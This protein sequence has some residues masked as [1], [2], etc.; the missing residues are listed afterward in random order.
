MADWVRQTDLDKGQLLMDSDFLVGEVIFI[1]FRTEN[2]IYQW[3]NQ[4]IRDV[5]IMVCWHKELLSVI[6]YY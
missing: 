1:L 2:Y 6:Y 4:E 5:W 3:L